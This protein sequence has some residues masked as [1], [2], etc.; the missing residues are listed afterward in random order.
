M[1]SNEAAKTPAKESVRETVK[2]HTN[3]NGR[4]D[5]PDFVKKY[6]K[7]CQDLWTIFNNNAEVRRFVSNSILNYLKQKGL[8]NDS[9]SKKFVRFGIGKFSVIIDGLRVDYRY[10]E[11]WFSNCFAAG[12]TSFAANA[13]LVLNDF[14]LRETGKTF[15]KTADTKEIEE[16][17]SANA[18]IK[19]STSVNEEEENPQ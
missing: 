3:S 18:N 5:L 8:L 10:T 2:V 15:D 17:V 6:P 16:I 19:S 12:F 14:L 7:H 9:A 1:E 13:Q 4:K 11:P